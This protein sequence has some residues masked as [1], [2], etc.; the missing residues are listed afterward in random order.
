MG[1]ELGV[2]ALEPKGARS[3][4]ER[5]GTEY[6]GTLHVHLPVAAPAEH[7][8]KLVKVRVRII[9]RFT[10]SQ[11]AAHV[12]PPDLPLDDPWPFTWR[13]E[14]LADS[15]ACSPEKTLFQAAQT[16]AREIVGDL[17]FVSAR[18]L[19]YALPGVEVTAMV[20]VPGLE[21]S[22]PLPP[23]G[24]GGTAWHLQVIVDKLLRPEAVPH[25]PRA[26]REPQ[27]HPIY[28]VDLAD[29]PSDLATLTSF[30]VRHFPNGVVIR[31]LATGAALT[32]RNLEPWDPNVGF[33]YCFN[34]EVRHWKKGD[35]LAFDDFLHV[36]ITENIGVRFDRPLTSDDPEDNKFL[37][38]LEWASKVTAYLQSEA[39]RRRNQ[40]SVPVSNAGPAANYFARELYSLVSRPLEEFDDL[41]RSNEPDRGGVQLRDISESR[42]FRIEYVES[43]A[44]LKPFGEPFRV[45]R[46]VAERE[47]E[48]Y[49][50]KELMTRSEA[51][52]QVREQTLLAIEMVVGMVPIVGDAIDLADLAFAATTGCDRNGK[53]VGSLELAVMGL[54]CV[55]AFGE[56]FRSLT[57]AAR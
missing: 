32:L 45:K 3:Y 55:P 26:V 25:D 4:F 52:K 11:R 30:Q 8:G 2:I 29:R 56:I 15:A 37:D 47:F 22:P 49:L 40:R 17:E 16:F 23:A 36:Q 5:D 24:G 18:I 7:K 38:P 44:D 53:P 50:E 19:V 12:F 31:H 9:D 57:R 20:D 51:A 43:A 35:R 27:L 13:V 10:E 41:L 14:V 6:S 28:P 42:F 39:E 21:G 54:V 34:H 1:L 48:S 46:D 33:T